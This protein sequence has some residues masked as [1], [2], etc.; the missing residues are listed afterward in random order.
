MENKI[1]EGKPQAEEEGVE[2]PFDQI[3][4]ESLAELIKGFILREGTDYGA[5]EARLD[6]K[7]EQIRN[8]LKR[9]EVKIVFDLASE[10]FSIMSTRTKTSAPQNY[11]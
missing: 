7:I 10:S 3:P 4:A 1:Y 6:T 11:P 9:K 2:V 5:Q 8:Q